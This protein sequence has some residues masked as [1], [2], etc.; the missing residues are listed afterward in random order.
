MSNSEYS[1]AK[2][3]L[4]QSIAAS[5]DDS[6]SRQLA[7]QKVLHGASPLYRA[8]LDGLVNASKKRR[9]QVGGA[10]NGVLL[11]G[12]RVPRIETADGAFGE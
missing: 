10:Q 9:K 1:L 5:I 8:T 2:L 6:P 12:R 7:R 4:E 11:H 3:R